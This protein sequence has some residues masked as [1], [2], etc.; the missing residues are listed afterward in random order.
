MA[1]IIIM[2]CVG[3]MACTCEAAGVGGG[4]GGGGGGGVA[5]VADIA[6][7]LLLEDEAVAAVAHIGDARDGNMASIAGIV[8][9]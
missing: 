1:C 4:G 5:C 8:V 9:Y 6:E 3:D 7:K 2:T